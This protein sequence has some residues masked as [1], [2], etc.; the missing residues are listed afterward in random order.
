MSGPRERLQKLIYA[1]VGAGES[2]VETAQE[3]VSDAEKREKRIETLA[4]KGKK[5]VSALEKRF[6]ERRKRI[7]SEIE[8]RIPQERIDQLLDQA[9]EALEP[10]VSRI[11]GAAVGSAREESAKGKKKSAAESPVA[12]SGQ[13]AAS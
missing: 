4:K 11:P 9:R 6:E 3:L 8:E 13:K 1:A 5:R 10:I 12:E 7:R 2:W